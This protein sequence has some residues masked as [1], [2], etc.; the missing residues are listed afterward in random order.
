M[1]PGNKKIEKRIKTLKNRLGIF[2]LTSQYKAIPASEAISKEEIAA[3]LAVKFKDFLEEPT[4]KPPII[5]DISTSWASKYILKTT[6]L[7][8]LDVYS[9]HTFQPK[10]VVTRA[11]MAEILWRLINYLKGKGYKFI[12]QIPLE[13]IKI[14]DVSPQNVYYSPILQIISY[15]IMS[16][17]SE[18]T[19]NPDLPLSGQEAE[20]LLNIILTLIK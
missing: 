18:K 12:R 19:F 11:E 6:T 8:I 7:G 2:E 15:D 13:K 5:I 17:S 20:R 9:N 1:E 4:S 10:K 14:S 3:L 16:L